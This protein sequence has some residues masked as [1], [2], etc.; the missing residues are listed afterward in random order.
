MFKNA[1]GGDLN[2]FLGKGI[3]LQGDL[4][5]Q[6]TFRI[7]GEFSG[8]IESNGELLVGETGVVNAEVQV[9]RVFVS[10]TLRGTVRTSTKTEITAVGK[11]FA[12]VETPALVIEDGA[13]FEGRCSMESARAS[14]ARDAK[15]AVVTHP[16]ADSPNTEG[17]RS[18]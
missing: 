13:L 11:V 7:D 8:K 10:G 18:S 16:R 12:D 2:G 3:K 15:A 9:S 1:S 4:H 17:Q 6:Y 5:F 14:A